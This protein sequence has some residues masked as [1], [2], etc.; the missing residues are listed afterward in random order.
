VAVLLSCCSSRRPAAATGA[1]GVANLVEM[2]V[3]M[4][5]D[6]VCSIL[7]PKYGRRYAPFSARCSSTS[8]S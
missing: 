5:Y 2:L 4:L 8:G 3:E 7:G 6:F 1:E